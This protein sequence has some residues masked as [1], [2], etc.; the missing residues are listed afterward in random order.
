MCMLS[1]YI[2]VCVH[3]SIVYTLVVTVH[4]IVCVHL[5]VYACCSVDL[6]LFLCV[7]RKVKR[8]CLDVRVQLLYMLSFMFVTVIVRV[9]VCPT[10]GPTGWPPAL[11]VEKV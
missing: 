1:L 7:H 2:L 8:Y 10:P 9:F 3:A 5:Y 6:S 4:V 11:S